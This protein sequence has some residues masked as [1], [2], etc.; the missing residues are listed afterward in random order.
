MIPCVIRHVLTF[1]ESPVSKDRLVTMVDQLIRQASDGLRI[2]SEI[3][4][5]HDLNVDGMYVISGDSLRDLSSG[6]KFK[7]WTLDGLI[8]ISDRTP[9]VR[10][11][12]CID[13]TNGLEMPYKS[14]VEK[15]REEVGS[16]MI[17]IWPLHHGNDHF[18][19][20]E[21]NERDGKIYH[22]D[23]LFDEKRS[24][25]VKTIVEVSLPAGAR[26]TSKNL[27]PR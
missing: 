9:Y 20:L 27:N 3:L 26:D 22:Y 6:K 4:G 24:M 25:T 12:E 5:V 21:I 8:R 10:Y 13:L 16:K 19:L 1:I 2:S 23:S 15:A 14:K 17:Y 11:G 7:N 18:T